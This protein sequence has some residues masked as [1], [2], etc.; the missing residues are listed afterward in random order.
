MREIRNKIR[1][2]IEFLKDGQ[3]FKVGELRFEIN[4][5]AVQVIGWSQYINLQN[6]TKAKALD[7]LE[8]IK[9][10]FFEMKKASPE[11]QDF[12]KEKSVKFSLYFDDYGKTSIEICTERD[13]I[14]I[15]R[16]K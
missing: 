16:L 15:W 1:T 9:A 4:E 3:S 10:L 2:A 11:L 14:F 13:G 12:I 6:V 7:E 5:G 8:E